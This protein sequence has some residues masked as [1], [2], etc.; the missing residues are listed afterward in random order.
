MT[1]T[2]KLK[3][4]MTHNEPR[5]AKSW[6]AMF[7]CSLSLVYQTSNRFGLHSKIVADLARE[8]RGS[9]AVERLGKRVEAPVRVKALRA[10]HLENETRLAYVVDGE[11]I[12]ISKEAK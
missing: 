2:S 7:G 6:A 3:H 12:I 8:S 5:S 9:I 1:N 10:A 4:A 11:R